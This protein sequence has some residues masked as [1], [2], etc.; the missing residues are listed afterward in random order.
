MTTKKMVGISPNHL[1]IYSP[2]ATPTSRIPLRCGRVLGMFRLDR[3]GWCQVVA[4]RV[5]LPIPP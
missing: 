2:I 1:F 4:I 5:Y 3:I